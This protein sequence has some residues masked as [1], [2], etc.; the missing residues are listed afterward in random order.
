MS[1]MVDKSIR[2]LR[3]TISGLIAGVVCFAAL[4]YALK[5]SA[6][7]SEG[8]PRAEVL[9]AALALFSVGS[10]VGYLVQYRKMVAEVQGRA[11]EIRQASEPLEI[12][13]AAYRPFAIVG[14]GL[15]EG[16]SLFALVI[17]IA[18]RSEVALVGAGLGVALLVLHM[19]SRERIERLTES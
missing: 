4:A 6:A 17:Y 14:G 5:G 11:A 12:V 2:E 9:L 19:P 7:L 10:G 16:P 13:M 18:T 15:I 8:L 1:P 3:I